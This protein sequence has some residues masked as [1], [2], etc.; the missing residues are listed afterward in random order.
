MHK[1]IINTIDKKK[2]KW[3]NK[4]CREKCMSEDC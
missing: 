3:I 1:K 4:D 2:K